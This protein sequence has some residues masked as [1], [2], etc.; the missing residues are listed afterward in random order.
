MEKGVCPEVPDRYSGRTLDQGDPELF[1]SL[2]Y[3]KGG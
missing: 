3:V 2:Y 1:G